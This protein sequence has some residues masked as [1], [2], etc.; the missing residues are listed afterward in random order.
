MFG[1]NGQNRQK[2]ASPKV[3]FSI[4]VSVSRHF[5]QYS[6][7][8]YGAKKSTLFIKMIVS[9]KEEASQW[10]R[11]LEVTVCRRISFTFKMVEW[12]GIDETI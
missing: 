10:K 5:Y 9:G 8:S 7:I 11:I 12:N 4:V 1:N 2:L 6:L 3:F